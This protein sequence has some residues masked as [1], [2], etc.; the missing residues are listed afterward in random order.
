M[1][2]VWA[3]PKLPA[4]QE[5]GSRCGQGGWGGGGGQ[6]AGEPSAR[7]VG[8]GGVCREDASPSTIPG[9]PVFRRW[10]WSVPE[11]A[12]PQADTA[13]LLLW[14]CVECRPADSRVAGIEI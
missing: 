8:K 14:V 11:L 2:I 1:T 7:G 3:F 9:R 13:R 6:P 5:R 12:G 10:V 4:S